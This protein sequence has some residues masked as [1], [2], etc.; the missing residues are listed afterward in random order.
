MFR[1]S[2]V[3]TRNIGPM[4]RIDEMRMRKVEVEFEVVPQGIE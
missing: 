4:K 3:S 1:V 2:I